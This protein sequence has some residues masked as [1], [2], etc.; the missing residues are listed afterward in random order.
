MLIDE[1]FLPLAEGLID[2]TF[3]T[4]IIYK[5]QKQ[6]KYNPL[7]G[8]TTY[9]LPSASPLI[10]ADYQNGTAIC[11]PFVV[12]D[13]ESS[14]AGDGTTVLC[15]DPTLPAGAAEYDDADILPR[16]ELL[17]KDPFVSYNINAGVLSRKRV[18]E[19]GSGATYEISIWVHHGA[20]GVPFLPLTGDAIEYDATEWKVT[21]VNPTY[22]SKALIASKLTARAA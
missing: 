19:G 2:T 15:D 5:R 3:P 14:E 22:S 7:T 4:P 18:E 21:T 20:T 1:T 16:S 13:Y 9:V 17:T 11:V 12:G 6:Q 8:E 10:A